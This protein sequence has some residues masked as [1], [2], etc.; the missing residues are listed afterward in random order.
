MPTSPSNGNGWDKWAK[1]VLFELERL[2]KEMG[3]M[4][5][6]MT[7]IQGEMNDKM[8]LIHI[9]IA[10]LK[11]KAGVWGLVGGAIPTVGIVL[12]FILGKLLGR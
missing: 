7:S 1:H 9:E 11:V 12:V 5:D 4:N 6:K 3:E 2:N 8:T 10:K